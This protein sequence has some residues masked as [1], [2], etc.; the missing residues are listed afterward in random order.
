MSENIVKFKAKTERLKLWVGLVTLVIANVATLLTAISAHNK[1]EKEEI[2]K[3]SYNE[4]SEAISKISEDNVE[5]YKDVSGIRGYLAGLAASKQIA[6]KS[7]QPPPKTKS[8]PIPQP[9]ASSTP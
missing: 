8:T 2:A 9:S 6:P 7:N 3:A 1:K 4:L 5:L